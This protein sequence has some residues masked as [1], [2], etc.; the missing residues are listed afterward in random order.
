[1]ADRTSLTQVRSGGAWYSSR[2]DVGAR[3]VPGALQE[4]LRRGTK[5]MTGADRLAADLEVRFTGRVVTFHES[6]ERSRLPGLLL[7]LGLWEALVIGLALPPYL[8]RKR[9][10]QELP[11]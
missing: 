1:M 8:L 7:G 6:V 3:D 10:E 9:V 4:L 2:L 11:E 5:T